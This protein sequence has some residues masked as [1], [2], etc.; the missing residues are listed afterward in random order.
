MLV[1]ARTVAHLLQQL[2]GQGRDLAEQELVRRAYYF[3][4]PLHSA[5]FE[6]DGTPFHVHGLGVASI[7]SQVGAPVAVLGAGVLHNAF[8]TGDWADGRGVG[9]HPS[10]LERLRAG[11][12]AEVATILTDLHRARADRH[13]DRAMADPASL[14]AGARWSV[15]LDLAD[16][17]DKWDDGR[18]YFGSPERDDRRFVDAH[19][20]GLVGL[21]RALGWPELADHFRAVFDRVGADEVPP[22]LLLGRR[23]SE[24]VL[25]PSA[26]SR[27]SVALLERARRGRW[28]V[29][30]WRGSVL[31]GNRS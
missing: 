31:S 21:A 11:V 3:G 26:R 23:Y 10:R 9:V 18:I 8:V 4:T 22:S 16:F 15:L 7:A 28:R 29:R 25:P 27:L 30:R 6:V 2:R 14:S 5:R 24:V 17:C 13:L 20:D 1:I 12:G 19:R